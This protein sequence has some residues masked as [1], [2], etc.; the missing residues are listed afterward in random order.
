[1]RQVWHP[2]SLRARLALLA[3]AL[4]S[5]VLVVISLALVHVQQSLLMR[6]V[7]EALVQRADN[8]A[9]TVMASGLVSELPT[10]G[11]REDS[12]LQVLAPD[13]EVSAASANVRGSRAVVKPLAGGVGDRFG[14]VRLPRLSAHRYLVLRRSV[15]TGST[16][17]TLVVGKNID[18]VQESVDILRTSLGAG[19]PVVVVLLGLLLWSITGRALGPVERIRAE[20]AGI[21]LDELHRRLPVPPRG[22]EV[23]RLAETMNAMLERV[24]LASDRQLR[25]VADV[26]HELR[27][28]L[29]RI[30][31]SLD[32]ALAHPL[33]VPSRQTLEEVGADASYLEQLVDD[34]LLLARS[35]AGMATPPAHSVDLDDLVLAEA[36]RLRGRAQVTVDTSA[37]SAARTTGAS[38]EI[39][40]LVGNLADNAERHATSTVSFGLRELDDACELIVADD[41]SGIPPEHRAAVFTRFARLDDARSR[42]SGGSGLGLAIAADI[43]K[44]HGG[45]VRIEQG[46]PTGARV[47]VLLPRAD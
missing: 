21:G 13:G 47:V 5:V 45:S 19:V 6:G 8:I 43:V 30:R 14:F 25:F 9:A 28:P 24:Q 36:L 26:S 4:V 40:R 10:E 7:Q 33:L 37:V 17:H 39:S 20:V 15:T 38:R 32:V 46:S 42:E 44:R 29:T 27:S 22:D 35:D 3:T 1:M 31:S 41:G 34:L 2:R 16:H 12:F 23:A 11:D 18:D